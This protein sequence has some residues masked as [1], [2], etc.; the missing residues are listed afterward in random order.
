MTANH[1]SLGKALT[2]GKRRP[3]VHPPWTT[4]PLIELAHTSEGENWGRFQHVK[5]SDHFL[6][7][8]QEI[9]VKINSTMQTRHKSNYSL[10]T[11]SDFPPFSACAWTALQPVRLH[12]SK[13][14]HTQA[15]RWF[16]FQSLHS[17]P[18]PRPVAPLIFYKYLLQMGSFVNSI[19]TYTCMT[20]THIL[21]NLG[22]TIV[23]LYPPRFL[24]HT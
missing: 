8:M 24:I 13:S 23:L 12:L 15:E 2:L 11:L 9:E 18:P 20:F 1:R 6:L 7:E 19:W 5:A 16:H 3:W 4:H 10:N 22:T 17:S 14:C 21:L